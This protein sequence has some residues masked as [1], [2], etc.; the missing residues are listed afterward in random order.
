M[1]KRAH[2][3]FSEL[4]RDLA[5]VATYSSHRTEFVDR[6]LCPLCLNAFLKEAIDSEP[7][8]LTEEHI[9]PEALGGKLITL[10]CRSCNGVHGSQLDSQLVQMLRAHILWRES[11]RI[12]SRGT[13]VYP[14]LNSQPAFVL[15]IAGLK[16]EAVTLRLSGKPCA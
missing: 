11:E 13:S 8:E 12:P 1:Q 3:I 2:N 16:R 10:S 15:R 5:R 4:A 7:P 14:G 6:I 9:I